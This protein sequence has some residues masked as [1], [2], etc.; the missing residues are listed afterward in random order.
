MVSLRVTRL[1]KSQLNNQKKKPEEEEC[2]R[3]ICES[4]DV[5]FL[6]VGTQTGRY[7]WLIGSIYMNCEGVRGDENVFKIMRVKDVVRN[8]KDEGLKIMIGGI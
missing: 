3:V 4:E 8:A 2:E 1:T 7:E 5:C 6:K